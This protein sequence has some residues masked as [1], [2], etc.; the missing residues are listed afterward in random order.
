MR[1]L[2]LLLLLSACEPAKP[3]FAPLHSDGRH[4][5]DAQG[6]TIIL[7]GVNA[8]VNGVFDVTF[9]DGRQAVEEIP[10]FEAA[11]AQR[12]AE[13]GFNLL[14][15]PIN[16]SGVEPQPGQY[17]RAYL[18][19]VA[20]VVDLCRAHGILVLID[21][22]QDAW[23]KEIGE[24]GAPLWAIVPPPEKLLSGPLHDLG[25]R[26]LSAQVTKAFVS[27]FTNNAERLQD[28]FAAMMAVVAQR[29]AGDQAVLGYEIF[30][31]PQA[32]DEELLPF[33]EKVASAIRA[34][35][36][37]HLIAWE[38]S[39]YRNFTNVSPLGDKP[40]PVAGTIYAPHVYTAI[41]NNDPRYAAGTY[42][43]ALAQSW[44]DARHALDGADAQLA[45]TAW[46]VWKETSQASW[47]FF[48]ASGA[49]RA[50]QIA[51]ISRPYARAIGGDASSMK[52]DGTTLTVAYTGAAPSDIFFPSATPVFRCDGSAAT[53]TPLGRTVY[54]IQCP[55]DAAHTLTAS[56]L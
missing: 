41:F 5:R 18:D 2:P 31:E 9:S 35:D 3:R 54:Q 4:F 29:F 26:R 20:R 24:D 8:R 49:E 14:R 16:W 42:V 44:V 43:A 19:R 55:G 47:G 56:R 10:H 17:D 33:H 48:D 6:R 15:L 53:A 37:E 39:V 23:S 1:V 28:K 13:I 32:T 52:W 46:W 25:E 27:F 21:V 36:A 51:A 12:M 11:D 7:R 38:P 22:H 45:S 40:F 30:N 34:V 50:D